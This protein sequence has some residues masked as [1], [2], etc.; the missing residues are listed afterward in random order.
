MADNVGAHQRRTGVFEMLC[1]VRHV[2]SIP[3]VRRKLPRALR[4]MTAVYLQETAGRVRVRVRVGLAL[5]L[6]G[7]GLLGLGLLGLGLRLGSGI[8]LE[9]V[10]RC[11]QDGGAMSRR[12]AMTD[13]DSDM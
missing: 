7:L 1:A 5:G 3:C 2:G 12:D 4:T 10:G 11:Q 8:G 9:T 6:L 13:L